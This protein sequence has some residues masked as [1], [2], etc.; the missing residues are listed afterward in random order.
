MTIASTAIGTA[1]S[2]HARERKAVAM[3]CFRVAWRIVGRLG[4]R[5]CA[6]GGPDRLPCVSLRYRRGSLRPRGKGAQGSPDRRQP[7]YKV[8][9]PVVDS[10]RSES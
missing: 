7:T 3:L 4:A 6:I 9:A 8:P 2:P 5:P 10:L 1:S